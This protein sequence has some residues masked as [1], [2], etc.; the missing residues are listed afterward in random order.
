MKKRKAQQYW[1]GKNKIKIKNRKTE[2]REREKGINEIRLVVNSK[3]I[4][5]EKKLCCFFLFFQLKRSNYRGSQNLIA[6]IILFFLF[7]LSFL[8][9]T[10]HK[11]SL[12]WNI[13]WLIGWLDGWLAD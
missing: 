1:W 8:N 5:H 6:L 3:I 10:Q 2:E 12:A 4:K 7:I 13:R 9:S 11:M